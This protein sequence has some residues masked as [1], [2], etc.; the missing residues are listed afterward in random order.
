MPMELLSS[1]ISWIGRACDNE[2]D[3]KDSKNLMYQRIRRMPSLFESNAKVKRRRTKQRKV[4]DYFL[5][6]VGTE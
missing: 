2:H 5:L 1:A 6:M 4:S 3:M